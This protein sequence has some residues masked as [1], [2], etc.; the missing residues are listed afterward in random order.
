MK[1]QAFF[2]VLLVIF[3]A[4]LIRA[5]VSRSGP[6]LPPGGKEPEVVTDATF[7]ERVEG[8][9]PAVL[10]DCWAPWCGP[11]RQL[12]PV[13][14]QMAARYE[15][16]AVVAQLNVDDNPRVA[17]QLGIDAIPAVFVFKNGKVVERFVGVQS[18]SVLAKA[19]E[20]HL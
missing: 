17:Q 20:R 18:E 7:A 11:C 8:S 4:L 5:F 3:G 19:L 16:R 10:L 13:I 1:N 12:T 15:G 14:H 9:K 6:P 2:V